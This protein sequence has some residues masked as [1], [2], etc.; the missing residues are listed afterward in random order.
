M[1]ETSVFP[2][3]PAV[4]RL[5]RAVAVM[6]RAGTSEEVLASVPR[7]VIEL[8]F[9][10]VMLSLVDEEY[11]RP[12][13]VEI[14]ADTSW[15]SRVLDTALE[16]PQPIELTAPERRV[17]TG[18]RP[19][20]V[21]PPRDVH[22]WSKKTWDY[23]R[24][25]AITAY[26]ASP[27]V[28]NG[29]VIGLV[30]ADRGTSCQSVGGN[31]ASLLWSFCSVIELALAATSAQ[32]RVVQMRGHLTQMLDLSVAEASMPPTRRTQAAATGAGLTDRERHI[33]ELVSRGLS[34]GQIAEQLVI[35]EDTVKAHVK[36]VLAKT[37]SPN[38][39]AAALKWSRGEV[40]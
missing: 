20:I 27:I 33:L 6:R 1:S 35:S 31:H 9:E 4:E 13:A 11:W 29:R 24:P 22:P 16:M 34:N 28:S 40:A 37:Q 10:R 17:I 5:A 39:T 18:A 2:A 36:H 19:V 12:Q 15:S 38:R 30:H 21:P 7:A 14:T 8:G 23:R 3:T 26:I 32:E 25:R